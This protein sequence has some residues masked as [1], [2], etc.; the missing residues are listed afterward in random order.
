MSRLDEYGFENPLNL[1]GIDNAFDVGELRRKFDG[2]IINIK[3]AIYERNK[4]TLDRINQTII[5]LENKKANA[6]PEEAEAYDQKISKAKNDLDT[7]Q[8]QKEKLYD[9]LENRRSVIY[10]TDDVSIIIYHIVKLTSTYVNVTPDFR[11]DKTP[12]K[13]KYVRA[14][15]DLNASFKTPEDV[16][17]FVI[18]KIFITKYIDTDNKD[19]SRYAYKG[20]DKT[21]DG[22]PEYIY[23]VK[24][25]QEPKKIFDLID[26]DE[27]RVQAYRI[28]RF[29]FATFISNGHYS[30]KSEGYDLLTVLRRDKSGETKIYNGILEY[31]YNDMIQN[32]DFYGI[33]A[34]SSL[35]L[36]NAEKN[37][38][39]YIGCVIRDQ[40]GERK[41]VYDENIEYRDLIT[42]LSY[43]QKYNGRFANFPN[44]NTLIEYYE[45]MNQRVKEISDIEMPIFPQFNDD[46]G[47]G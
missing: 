1:I 45:I 29:A 38:F 3:S 37:N 11:Q 27:D 28:G 34:L 42:A 44:C 41:L 18:Q 21:Y 24:S 40:E 32:P 36:E 22:Y 8:K 43:A 33:V 35:A 5:D 25:D 39:G 4:S 12:E 19:L 7:M 14:V 13:T 10:S 17:K 47:R 15:N 16:H 6:L 30:Y 26:S 46:E 2:I 23:A 9:Q 31:N 20:N